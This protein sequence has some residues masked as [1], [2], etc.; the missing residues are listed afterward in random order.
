MPSR[1]RAQQRAMHAAASG[2]SFLGIPRK[3]GREYVKADKA[4]G[5][6]KLPETKHKRGE[7]NRAMDRA[8]GSA[9]KGGPR[10]S[11]KAARSFLG[12]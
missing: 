7:V 12:Q 2:R 10:G 8:R 9:K 4:R 5:P 11:A 3:V 6:V 1:S